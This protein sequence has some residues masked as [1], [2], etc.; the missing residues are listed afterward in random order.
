M[1]MSITAEI[2]LASLLLCFYCF[3]PHEWAESLRT[4]SCHRIDTYIAYSPP[5]EWP[6]SSKTALQTRMPQS[7]HPQRQGWPTATTKTAPKEPGNLRVNEVPQVHQSERSLLWGN[8]LESKTRLHMLHQSGESRRPS[9]K[10]EA[11]R[12]SC[13]GISSSGCWEFF[14]LFLSLWVG[15]EMTDIQNV[16]FPPGLFHTLVTRVT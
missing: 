14:K 11:L 5:F 6:D 3:N 13:Q 9:P 7:I 2:C 1:A 8:V 10:R 12:T 4:L 15:T 16:S